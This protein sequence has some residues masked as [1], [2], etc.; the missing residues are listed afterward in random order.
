MKQQ[1]ESL[2]ESLKVVHVVE[3]RDDLDVLEE[4]HAKDGEDKHDEEE[5]KSNV[6]QGWEGHH[7][8][9]EQ[10]SDALGTLDEP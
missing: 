6:D 3:S 10:G 5:E 4:G 2:S 8:G 7:Q 9:E 1:S